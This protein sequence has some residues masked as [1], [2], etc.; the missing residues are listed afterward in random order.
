MGKQLGFDLAEFRRRTLD[1]ESEIIAKWNSDAEAPVVSVLCNT[2]NQC[3]YIED[4]IRGF[5]IQRTSFP[6]EVIVHDDASTDGTSEIIKYYA[7]AYPKIIKPVMQAE[8]QYSQGRKPST[9]GFQQARGDY[10]AFCEGD[11][12]WICRDKLS[13]EVDAASK[14]GA[15]LVF[16][17]AISLEND[18][19]S[20]RVG[21]CRKTS[22]PVSPNEIIIGGG[23][24][25]P[26][27]SLLVK[28]E[29]IGEL[30]LKDWFL[31]APVGDLY[32]QAY[33]AVK[34]GAYFINKDT[35]VYRTRSS[36]SWTASERTLTQEEFFLVAQLSAISGFSR[37]AAGVSSEL[38][39]Q[40]KG[41]AYYFSAL[42]VLSLGEFL[43]FDQLMTSADSLMKWKS[44][45]FTLL[46]ML[47][48]FPEVAFLFAK[49]FLTR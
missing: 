13:L 5:L 24:Y 33:A 26:T 47:K 14:S 39:D 6:F 41:N 15:G 25:C 3:L 21:R 23:S 27:A 34:N 43:K 38:I 49:Y 9:I 2:Y 11:D 4:A 31:A 7:R 32:I 19:V 36:G 30:F 28:Q 35:C 37:S 8:N 48:R 10:V 44:K 12:F 40:M 1:T 22:G 46:H 45:G 42:K 20:G 17:S 29:I 18:T 16:T